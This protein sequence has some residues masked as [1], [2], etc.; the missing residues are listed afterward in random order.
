MT[1]LFGAL[2]SMSGL[3]LSAAMRAGKEHAVDAVHGSDDPGS[4]WSDAFED[5]E[6]EEDVD[7]DDVE[8]TYY[9]W[10]RG[11]PKPNREKKKNFSVGTRVQSLGGYSRIT[12]SE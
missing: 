1:L 11:A 4:D 6:F 2:I 10:C 9:T 3:T 5:S 7:E 12:S 8:Y